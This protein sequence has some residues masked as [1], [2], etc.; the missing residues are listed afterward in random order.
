M[1][2]L[3]PTAS[4][5]ASVKPMLATPR[6]MSEVLGATMAQVSSAASKTAPAPMASHSLAMAV[7]RFSVNSILVSR[8]VM[9]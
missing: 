9:K 8:A 5:L 4:S 6:P 2:I 3:P 7:D 1:T